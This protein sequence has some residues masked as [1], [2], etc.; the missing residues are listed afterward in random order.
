MNVN[1]SHENVNNN[2][3]KKQTAVEK[4]NI[5]YDED[6]NHFSII[7][8]I[9]NTNGKPKK[10]IPN[11]KS[12]INSI[13]TKSTTQNESNELN[14]S[15]YI[16]RDAKGNTI[17]KK[18]PN[19]KKSN[20]HVYFVDDI[21]KKNKLAKIIKVESYK[22]FN[23]STVYSTIYEENCGIQVVQNECCCSIF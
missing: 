23:K 5:I 20:H 3:E 11:C 8:M 7:K 2:D 15:K 14:I 16:R 21:N 12:D 19:S 1:F 17:R 18:N 10:N 22:D 6:I 9:N 4:S 13:K